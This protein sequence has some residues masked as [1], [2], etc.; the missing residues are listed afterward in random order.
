MDGE[1]PY[2]AALA[3]RFELRNLLETMPE[4]A[5]KGTRFPMREAR[6]AAAQ[7]DL[8]SRPVVVL[9]KRVAAA[10]GAE[11]T[12]FEWSRVRAAHCVTIPHPSGINLALNDPAIRAK[13]GTILRALGGP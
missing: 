2:R 9:G 12:Y 7:L 1:D 3:L 4:R 10:L 13:T 6:R 5:G 8:G 11:T